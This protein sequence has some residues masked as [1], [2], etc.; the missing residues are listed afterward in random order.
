MLKKNEEGKKKTEAKS[1]ETVR[2]SY[3]KIPR[4]KGSG[5]KEKKPIGDVRKRSGADVMEM[6]TETNVKKGRVSEEVSP[7]DGTKQMKAGLWEQSRGN[8]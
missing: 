6:D 2:R 3:R 4:E 7:V 1:M 8:Q 5:S